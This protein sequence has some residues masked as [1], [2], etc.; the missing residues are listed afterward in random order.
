MKKAR[1][2]KNDLFKYEK[3][4]ILSHL[5]VEDMGSKFKVLIQQ[6]EMQKY[7]LSGLRVH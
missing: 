1:A 2:Q 5:L 3:D 7:E 6:K 4:A